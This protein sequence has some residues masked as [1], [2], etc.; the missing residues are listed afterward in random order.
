MRRIGELERP[1]IQ[2]VMNPSRLFSMVSVL[3]VIVC[4]GLV[5]VNLLVP[6]L[7]ILGTIVVAGIAFTAA[8]W[9]R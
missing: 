3:L 2:R 6:A 8:N 7:F 9:P 5:A 1:D 4:L